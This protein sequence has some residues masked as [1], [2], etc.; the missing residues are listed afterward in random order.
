MKGDGWV[1]DVNFKNIIAFFKGSH[2]KKTD[3][4]ENFWLKKKNKQKTSGKVVAGV[5]SKIL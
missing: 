2:P 4:K 1:S 3:L 5:S